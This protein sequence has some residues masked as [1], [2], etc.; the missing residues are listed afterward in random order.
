ML[1]S[2]FVA[3][4]GTYTVYIVNWGNKYLPT[5]DAAR[6]CLFFDAI[7]DLIHILA[8]NNNPGGFRFATVRLE[9]TTKPE[10]MSLC[11]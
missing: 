3:L 8:C 9:L 11:V 1:N 7:Y 2:R 6:L 10:P 5:A 4:S